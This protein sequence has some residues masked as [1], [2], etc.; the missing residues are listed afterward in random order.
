MT[1]YIIGLSLGLAVYYF[2]PLAD[3]EKSVIL[4]AFILPT[5][6]SV[7]AYSIE[8]KY[9]TKFAGMLVNST[10]VI[11]IPIMWLIALATR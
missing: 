6:F 3:V 5:S 11:S 1:K 4:M 9:D 8:F 10:I 7:I 2:S